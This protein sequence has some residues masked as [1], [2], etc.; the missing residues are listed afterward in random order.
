MRMPS[1][2]VPVP[3]LPVTAL[4]AVPVEEIA[5]PDDTKTPW[6]RFVPEPP[7]PVTAIALSTELILL[8]AP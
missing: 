3:A 8:L 5:A 6:L 2:D 4:L 1:P 7:V